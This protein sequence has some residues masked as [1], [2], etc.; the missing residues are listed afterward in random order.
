MSNKT[1]IAW[2]ERTWNPAVGCSKISPGCKNCYAEK[3][4]Y[5]IASTRGA[6]GVKYS[7]L[8]NGRAGWNGKVYCDEKA[9][10]IPKRWKQPSRIFVP[11]MGDLFHKEVSY[12]FIDKVYDTMLSCDWHTFQVLTKR[13]DIALDY[14]ESVKADQA[15][16]GEPTAIDYAENIWFGTTAE[17]QEM[18]DKRIPILLQIPAAVRF[19]SVEPMLGPVDLYNKKRDY[20]GPITG[21]KGQ[22]LEDGL[23][24]VIIG[25]ESGPGARECKTEWVRGLVGQCQSASVPVFVKQ[26]QMYKATNHNKIFESADLVRSYYCDE[27]VKVKRFLTKKIE[28]FPAD[29][30]IREYPK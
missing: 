12:D 28:Q 27:K 3:M 11:S 21:T 10:S 17:N 5:R 1:K 29:L 6:T 18:A 25:C 23:N 14:Y 4:A 15:E 20:L 26:L 19:V 7:K 2:T 24:W 22:V 30:M 9:L 13:P 16:I 8:L